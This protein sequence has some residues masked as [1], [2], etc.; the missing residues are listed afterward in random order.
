V[1][2]FCQFGNLSVRKY[3]YW[4]IFGKVTVEIL[5]FCNLEFGKKNV[6]LIN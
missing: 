5:A 4:S 2:N 1:S 6:A 3:G